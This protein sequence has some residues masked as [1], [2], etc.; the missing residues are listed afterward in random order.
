MDVRLEKKEGSGFMNFYEVQYWGDGMSMQEEKGHVY[1]LYMPSAAFDQFMDGWELY[2]DEF[3]E[4]MPC[5]DDLV[6][7]CLMEDENRIV[8]YYKDV[9]H[10]H[11]PSQIEEFEKEGFPVDHLFFGRVSC[12]MGESVK[13]IPLHP[14]VSL[15]YYMKKLVL[16]NLKCSI[17]KDVCTIDEEVKNLLSPSEKLEVVIE[18]RSSRG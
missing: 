17:F 14:I 11:S 15:T 13:L 16:A 7:M 3:F 9:V 18:K 6:V 4:K 12:V 1:F 8:G 10:F 2:L 5:L